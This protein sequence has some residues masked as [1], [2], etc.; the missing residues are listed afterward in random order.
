MPTTIQTSRTVYEAINADGS[1]EEFDTL[2]AAR[3]GADGRTVQTRSVTEEIP[4]AYEVRLD[5]RSLGQ[6]DSV[7]AAAA[8]VKAHRGAQIHVVAAD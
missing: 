2:D 3:A 7:Q 5:G 6:F 4:A 1:T 8:L